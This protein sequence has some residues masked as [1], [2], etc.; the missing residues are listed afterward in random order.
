[1]EHM[2]QLDRDIEH[3]VKAALREDVGEGDLT[4]LSCLEPGPMKAVIVAKSEGT[5]SGLRPALM[6]FGT[7]DSANI[8]RPKKKNGDR[9]DIGDTIIELD[10]FNQT[11]LTS[12]RAALNFLGRLSGIAT[13]T[14]LY[15]KEIAGT[16]AQILDTRKTAPGYRLLEKEAVLH[17]GGRNH[18]I[19]LYDMVLIKDNHIASTGSI[20][21]AVEATRTFLKT[22]EFRLQFK[23]KADEIAVEVEVCTLE[24][25]TEAIEA[26]VDQLLLDNR[27]PSELK[28]MVAAARKLNRQ[29]K[30]EASGN[31]SLDNVAEV[32]AT[33]VDFISVGALTHSAPSSDFSM[34]V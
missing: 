17:G 31:V 12:E 18:R 33:G 29:V 22:V 30:L 3:L 2:E 16:G 24:Q 28:E 7:V 1:M 6:T 11:L 21:A 19:G 5:L 9:F 26:G 13:L 20:T 27:T 32:A 10:G 23:R 4:S 8:V 34:Q 14:A 15:V 25:L